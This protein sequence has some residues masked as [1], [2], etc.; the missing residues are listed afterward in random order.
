MGAAWRWGVLGSRSL[1]IISRRM[2]A[3]GSRRCC[4]RTSE[5]SALGRRS[6]TVWS[7]AV[8]T[9]ELRSTGP[10]DWLRAGS[11][12]GCPYVNPLPRKGAVTRLA[13]SRNQQRW[14]PRA[15]PAD[16]GHLAH[17]SRIYSLVVRAWHTSLRH[18]GHADSYLRFLL[19]LLD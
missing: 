17:N 10:F 19:A 14:Q 7:A 18:H 2:A 4:G 12:D 15:V 5:S 16:E 8:L 13:E 1:R 9:V 3:W 11:R 6:S